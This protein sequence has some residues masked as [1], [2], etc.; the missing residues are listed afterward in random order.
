MNGHIITTFNITSIAE[1]GFVKFYITHPDF[2][3]RIKKHIGK[4]SCSDYENYQY[5][6]RIEANKYFVGKTVTYDYTKNF[7]NDYVERMK[8]VGSIF[9]HVDEFIFLKS[10]KLNK[11]LDKPLSKSTINTALKAIDNFRDYLITKNLSELPDVINQNLLDDFYHS[12][13]HKQT[14]RAKLHCRLKEYIKFLFIEKG[15]SIDKSFM[16]SNFSEQY[17][18]QENE[19]NDRALTIEEM[20]KLSALRTEFK[21]GNIQFPEYKKAKTIPEKLQLKQREIKKSNLKK[22]LDCFLFMSSLGLYISDVN[23]INLTIKNSGGSTYVTYRRAKNNTY[24]TG[25]PLWD[26]GCFWGETIRKEYGIK[27]GTNFPLNL[28]LNH[29]NKN[30]K[31]I[32]S[33]AG[34]DFS[35][36]SKMARKTFA[37]RYYFDYELKIEEIQMMLG[38]KDAKN[39]RHY[40]RITDDDFAI[41]IQKKLRP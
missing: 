23:K 1:K 37:S 40:L 36:T 25:I 39:T 6:L 14:Y 8:H 7:V 21:N 31:I 9:N 24:S 13:T 20:N 35:L 32:S 22:T 19:E 28:S 12:L 3:G 33:L 30:L 16:R 18:N 10:N 17:D 38:H 34:L 29:F 2:K 41:K 11:N 5:E 27:S 15:M 26:Y 4:G